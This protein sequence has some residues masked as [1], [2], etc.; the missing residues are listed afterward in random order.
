MATVRVAGYAIYLLLHFAVHAL[1]LLPEDQ[2]HRSG[3]LAMRVVM[4]MLVLVSALCFATATALA[5]DYADIP[6]TE[7]KTIVLDKMKMNDLHRRAEAGELE[8]QYVLGVAYRQ[9]GSLLPQN[10]AQSVQWFRRAADQNF[11]RAQIAL[12]DAYMFGRGVPQDYTEAAR[13]LQRAAEQGHA[14]AQ[15]NLGTMFSQ[16]LGVAKNDIEAARWRLKAAEQGIADAQYNLGVM[17]YNG[18]GVAEDDEEAVRWFRKAAEQ[19]HSHAIRELRE[20]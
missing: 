11:Q 6:A 8:A 14:Q 2:R 17:Y 15:T 9:G 20:M 13:W 19:G 10:E 7:N 5:Q 4:S 1:K 3:L 12:A 18:D 16:G